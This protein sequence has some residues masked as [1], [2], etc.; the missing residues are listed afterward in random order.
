MWVWIAGRTFSVA[1]M[2]ANLMNNEDIPNSR[3]GLW[4]TVIWIACKVREQGL[5]KVFFRIQRLAVEDR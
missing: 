1:R 2:H 3:P 5:T 4:R